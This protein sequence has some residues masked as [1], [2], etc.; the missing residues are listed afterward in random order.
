MLLARYREQVQKDQA[1]LQAAQRQNA[2][3]LSRAYQSLD[4]NANNTLS[5][6]EEKL[7]IQSYQKESAQKALSQDELFKAKMRG[8]LLDTGRYQSGVVD[9]QMKQINAETDIPDDLKKAYFKMVKAGIKSRLA[10][11]NDYKQLMAKQS[12]RFPHLN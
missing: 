3:P 4:L 8:S 5:A 9:Q 1:A 2:R 6:E 12:D 7:N 10:N 11:D